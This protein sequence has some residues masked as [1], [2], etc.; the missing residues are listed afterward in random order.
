MPS[1]PVALS[2]FGSGLCALFLAHRAL[3]YA[4]VLVVVVLERLCTVPVLQK[5]W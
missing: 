2:Q 1:H 4:L 3:Y 5:A